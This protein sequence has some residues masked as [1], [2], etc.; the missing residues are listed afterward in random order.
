MPSDSDQLIN[1]VDVMTTAGGMPTRLVI[2][3]EAMRLPPA[4]LAE[5]ILG[6]LRR[7]HASALSD[8]LTRFEDIQFEAHTPSV[9]RSRQLA[10]QI[11]ADVTRQAE[12]MR[13]ELDSLRRKL[14]E[15][16]GG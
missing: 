4:R 9:R 12:Q 7:A 8:L 5:V 2:H 11:Q 3:P 6:A 14:S 13:A 15:L 1:L 10:E 16:T